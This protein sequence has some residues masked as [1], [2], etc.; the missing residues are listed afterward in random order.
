MAD[1]EYR[2]ITGA[3][4]IEIALPVGGTQQQNH[5]IPLQSTDAMSLQLPVLETELLQPRDHT[6]GTHFQSSCVI[7]TPPTDTP[8]SRSMN[9]AL[10]DF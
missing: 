9:T 4:L 1:T 2:P 3:P 5:H 6:R 7:Q 8:F 10:R